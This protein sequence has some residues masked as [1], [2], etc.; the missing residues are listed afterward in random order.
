MQLELQSDDEGTIQFRVAN[1]G[2]I[3]HLRYPEVAVLHG[4]SIADTMPSLRRANFFDFLHRP[5]TVGPAT[6]K[7]TRQMEPYSGVIFFADMSY[8]LKLKLI[9]PQDSS[10]HAL[11]GR[12]SAP[13]L[14]SQ[15]GKLLIDWL[16]TKWPSW[17]TYR[18]QFS[19]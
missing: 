14:L 16:T 13:V 18:Q 10:V 8:L 15:Q 9:T 5:L 19:L 11:L 1:Q 12:S 17:P 6:T 2:T 3:A 7:M 4:L